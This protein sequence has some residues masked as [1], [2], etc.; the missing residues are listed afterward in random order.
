MGTDNGRINVVDLRSLIQN[1]CVVGVDVMLVMW[2]LIG[3]TLVPL[4]QMDR[5]LEWRIE[6]RRDTYDRGI[7]TWYPPQIEKSMAVAG[8]I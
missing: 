3:G 8:L 4:D 7:G 1:C 2:V 6:E 5:C